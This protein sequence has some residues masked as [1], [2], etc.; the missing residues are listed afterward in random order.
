VLFRSFQPQPKHTQR[1]THTHTHTHTHY[2]LSVK[3]GGLP[4]CL[5]RPNTYTYPSN[6]Y[7]SPFLYSSIF[8]PSFFFLHCF[9]FPLLPISVHILV[10][11]TIFTSFS[12]TKFQCLPVSLALSLPYSFHFSFD[13]GFL[14]LSLVHLKDLS[15]STDQQ[16]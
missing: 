15:G 12:Q 1:A 10:I 7:F 2:P 13:F 5:V 16:T 14:I 11:R 4:V 3:T 6:Q 9:H 8:H